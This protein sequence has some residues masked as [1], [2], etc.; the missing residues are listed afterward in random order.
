MA[1]KKSRELPNPV[2]VRLPEDLLD[3]IREEADK[4]ERTLSQEIRW[5]LLR[6]VSGAASRTTDETS[7]GDSTT[8]L[9]A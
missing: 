1:P 6:S 9:S 8:A 3:L 4:S 5:R 2:N 7:G